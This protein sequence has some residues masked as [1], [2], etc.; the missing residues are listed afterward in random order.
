MIFESELR[1]V[2]FT[3]PNLCLWVVIMC[4]AFASKNLKKPKNLKKN[5]KKPRFLPV[6]PRCV[7]GQQLVTNHATVT[8]LINRINAFFRLVKR[9]GYID[10]ALTVD[11]LLSQSRV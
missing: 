3:W 9:F 10:T 11:E 8:T 5:V 2:A 7:E 6:L 1:F 4:R